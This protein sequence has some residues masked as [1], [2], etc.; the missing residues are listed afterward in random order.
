V[1]LQ[2]GLAGTDAAI[3]VRLR[4]GRCCYADAIPTPGA[5]GR[6]RRHGRKFACN[7]EPTWSP[8]TA[9]L[10]V[11]EEQYGAVRVRAWGGLHPKQQPHPGKGTRRPRASVRGTLLL[12]EVS[13]LPARAQPP[14]RL[15]LWW[16]GR[17][18]PAL[19]LL[20]RAYVRRCDLEHTFRVARQT[21]NWT[22]PRVRLPEQADRWTWLVLAAYT[23]LRLL[24]PAVAAH[25]LPGE[26]PLAPRR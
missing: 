9:A 12:V 15:W 18:E 7:D 19:D 5:N 25:H 10:H 3:L 22:R 1:H 17:G 26:R 21:L 16:A 2:Q 13:R 24:K 23:L 11:Q 20:W 4:S 14:Q 8:P 6:P